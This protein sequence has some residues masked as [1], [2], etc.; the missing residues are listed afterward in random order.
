MTLETGSFV[1]AASPGTRGQ[2]G[3][4]G[5]KGLIPVCGVG[6]LRNGLGMSEPAIGVTADGKTARNPWR[7]NSTSADKG[8]FSGGVDIRRR[9]LRSA[10]GRNRFHSCCHRA[11]NPGSNSMPS[12][13]A[14]EYR[15]SHS[16]EEGL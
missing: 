3:Y 10:M 4:T 2:G 14:G 6:S 7:V 8:Q 11:R 9:R 16:E 13:L 15:T 5:S 1:V 12:R